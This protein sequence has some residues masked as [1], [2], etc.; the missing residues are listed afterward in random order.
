MNESFIATTKVIIS[1]SNFKELS[2]INFF[3]VMNLQYII[4]ESSRIFETSL[5]KLLSSLP[6][7]CLYRCSCM[8]DM[9]CTCLRVL[10][11]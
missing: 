10:D 1:F 9:P 11:L 2:D 6:Q 8:H 3:N 7:K 4:Q 5:K